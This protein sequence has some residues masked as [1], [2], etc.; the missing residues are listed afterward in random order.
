MAE[1]VEEFLARG[2]E[3]K[4][5]EESENVEFNPI[6]N[7]DCGCEGDYT[8]HSMRQGEKGLY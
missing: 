6:R 1:S 8:D 2:G 7:C 5:V 4:K 3:I